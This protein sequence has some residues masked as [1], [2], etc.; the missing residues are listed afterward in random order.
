MFF[1][2]NK[3]TPRPAQPR[4]DVPRIEYIPMSLAEL[5]A[6]EQ[7]IV[8]G[9]ACLRRGRPDLGSLHSNSM[10]LIGKLYR[11]AGA[12]SVHQADPAQLRI[13]IQKGDLVWLEAAI[14][15]IEQYQGDSDLG[16]QGRQLLNRFNALLGQQR[17][18]IYASGTPMFDPDA[19]AP[20]TVDASQLP[21]Y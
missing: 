21:A 3:R 16:A 20:V 18:V 4:H 2:R 9:E 17:A 1:R 13:P 5:R 10:E 11:G 8:H 7:V 6:F 14:R 12:A 19:P 15:D